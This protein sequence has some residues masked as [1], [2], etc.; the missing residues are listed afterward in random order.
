MSSTLSARQM[1]SIQCK[2]LFLQD[3]SFHLDVLP[4]NSYKD[5]IQ[6]V[7]NQTHNLPYKI[8]PFISIF[9][10]V[11]SPVS[12]PGNFGLSLTSELSKK[13]LYTAF[14]NQNLKECYLEGLTSSSGDSNAHSSLRTSTLYSNLTH[15]VHPISYTS[16]LKSCC[17][18]SPRS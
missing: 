17:Y 7:Q 1:H 5:H 2:D 6:F 11:I 12:L 16:S 3:T 9:S 15:S 18:K 14:Q 4:T 13:V 10:S 8:T